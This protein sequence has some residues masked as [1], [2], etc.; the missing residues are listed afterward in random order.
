MKNYI[1]Q[2]PE[3]YKKFLE[4]SDSDD[5]LEYHLRMEREWDDEKYQNAINLVLEVITDYKQ[6]DLIPT[7]IMFFFISSLPGIVDMISHPAFL[8]PDNMDPQA[9]N[10]YQEL[11]ARRSK[12]LQDLQQKF[13]SGELFNK[14]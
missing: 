8:N 4:L 3:S 12:E 1:P 9:L 5:S 14:E 2:Y 7:P 10:R 6:T 11:I 13:I